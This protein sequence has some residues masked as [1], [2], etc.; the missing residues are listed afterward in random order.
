MMA[1]PVQLLV[2][3]ILVLVLFGAGKLPQVFEELGKGV[4]ALR[5]SQKDLD[6]DAPTAKKKADD[7][8]AS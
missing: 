3:L 2:V 5:D 4:K 8:V 1:S 6:V 7:E